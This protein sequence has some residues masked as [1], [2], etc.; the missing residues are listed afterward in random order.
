MDS[1]EIEVTKINNELVTFSSRV[2]PWKY[3]E[4]CL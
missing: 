2:F 1:Y 4:F 3:Q